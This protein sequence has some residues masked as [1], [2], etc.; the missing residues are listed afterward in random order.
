MNENA[1]DRLNKLSEHPTDEM[2]LEEQIESVS[3]DQVL[4]EMSFEAKQ[5]MNNLFEEVVTEPIVEKTE[6]SDNEK[7]FKDNKEKKPRK[8]K[9]V[10]DKTSDNPILTQLSK[11]LIDDLK[12]SKYKFNNFDEVS[13]TQLF[14]Y[15]YSHF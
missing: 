1:L 11:D 6:D 9:K 7:L 12:Q 14:D 4:D 13:M 8:T 15:M 3:T 10:D 5:E 2:S